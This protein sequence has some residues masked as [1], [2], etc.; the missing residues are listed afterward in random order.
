MGRLTQEKLE[1][2]RKRADAATG[3][4]WTDFDG[5][6]WGGVVYEYDRLTE[7]AC[8]II[9][10]CRTTAD[11]EFIAHAREDIPVLLAEVERL[12]RELI[13]TECTLY[14]VEQ[15]LSRHKEHIDDIDDI[16]SEAIRNVK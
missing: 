12:Q 13:K 16:V 11:A 2:I 8:E 14:G 7:D 9:A 10:E 15:E 4:E 1:A 5:D 6:D 3:K